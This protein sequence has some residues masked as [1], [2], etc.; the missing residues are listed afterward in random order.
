MPDIQIFVQEKRG[1]ID[2][3]EARAAFQDWLN[4]GTGEDFKERIAWGFLGYA[5][6]VGRA[7][8]TATSDGHILL[9]ASLF[10]VRSAGPEDPFRMVRDEESP[11]CEVIARMEKPR[12][13]G[14]A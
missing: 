7:K 4:S 3:K 10:R 13:E 1:E 14:A 11:I 9:S 5:D 6:S 2:I 12:A 8:D